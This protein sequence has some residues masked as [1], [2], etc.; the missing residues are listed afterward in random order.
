[1]ADP[2]F[3]EAYCAKHGT[4]PADFAQ[5]VLRRTLYPHAR[6]LLPLC[7]FYNANHLAADMDLVRA[8]GELRRVR[9]LGDELSDFNH[10]P[11]NVGFWHRQMKVRIS[12][13]RLRALMRETLP[14]TADSRPP[15]AG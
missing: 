9:D 6:L 15:T 8:A 14:L 1:M 3:T 4:P 10:H 5:A 11:A 13:Q 2:T 7:R 12:T